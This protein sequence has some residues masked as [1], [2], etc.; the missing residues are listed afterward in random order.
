MI[1]ELTAKLNS[2][3]NWLWSWFVAP[4]SYL[5]SKFAAIAP[6]TA[7]DLGLSPGQTDGTIVIVLSLVSWLVFAVVLAFAWVSARNLTRYA[8]ALLRTAWY[9]LQI[10]VH[11]YKTRMVLKIRSLIPKR[12]RAPETTM[13]TVEFDDLDLAVLYSVSE[14][15]PGFTLSAPELAERMSLLP[16]RIQ[17]SLDKLS[18]NNMLK[19]AIGSTDGFDNYRL[20]ETGA[21]FVS[22]WQRRES[23]G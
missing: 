6:A 9:R 1:I 15:G 19:S 18:R 23:R 2:L 21:A 12:S 11:G 4:G 20:S 22:M 5:L 10:A 8:G 17:Q 16:A 13:P 3:G 7:F 14:Q